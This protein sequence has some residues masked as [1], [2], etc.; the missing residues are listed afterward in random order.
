M[1]ITVTFTNR[2]PAT[3]YKKLAAKLGLEPTNAECKAEV[4]RILRDCESFRK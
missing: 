4:G 3:I 1:K 2:N